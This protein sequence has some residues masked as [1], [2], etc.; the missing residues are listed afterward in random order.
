M[1]GVQDRAAKPA[2]GDYTPVLSMDTRLVFAT[3]HDGVRVACGVMGSGYPMLVLPIPLLSHCRL[4]VTRRGWRESCERLARRRQII[5]IDL[6]GCGMADRHASTHTFDD[7]LADIRAIYDVLRLE[8]ADIL[9]FGVRTPVAVRFAARHPE[10]VR[11]LVLHGVTVGPTAAA[12]RSMVEPAAL[13]LAAANWQLYVET[14]AARGNVGEARISETAAYM[15]KC[16]DQVS[17]L[18]AF[19][20]LN[21]TNIEG[22]VPLLQCPTLVAELE[23]NTLIASGHAEQFIALAPH[24]QLVWIPTDP[25]LRDEDLVTAVERFEAEHRVAS[26]NPHEPGD[27]RLTP[28]EVEVLR[29][30]AGGRSNREI[31]RDLGLSTRTVDRH[32]ANIY[33]KTDAHNRTEATLW[34]IAHGMVDATRAQ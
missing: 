15:H 29:L 20:A 19:K 31:A 14:L 22:D 3:S 21:A 18:A 9:A 4:D 24:A 33:N 6:R 28:R 23:S 25:D 1:D 8:V 5:R 27:E 11:R 32:V 17:A 10:R 12:G 7:Y 34:A 16:C 26:S 13:D 30:L 2:Q